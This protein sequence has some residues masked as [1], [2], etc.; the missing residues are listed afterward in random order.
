MPEIFIFYFNSD[1]KFKKR[2][3]HKTWHKIHL[4]KAVNN[5]AWAARS[6]YKLPANTFLFIYK[7][8][9]QAH[10]NICLIFSII[11]NQQLKMKRVEKAEETIRSLV[12]HWEYQSL[13]SILF[14]RHTLVI[15]PRTKFNTRFKR[16]SRIHQLKKVPFTA[17]FFSDDLFSAKANK[18]HWVNDKIYGRNWLNMLNFTQTRCEFF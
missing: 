9:L 14:E 15:F 3:T 4:F 6:Y 8:P 1:D 7:C 5:I 10:I 11:I 2:L 16:D 12:T 13:D 17:M 18:I